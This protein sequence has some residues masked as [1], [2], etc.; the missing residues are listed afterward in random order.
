MNGHR[1]GEQP[2]IKIGFRSRRL[3]RITRRDSHRGAG[4]APTRRWIDLGKPY[5]HRWS[6]L[7]KR[8][9]HKFFLQ[10]I[11][12]ST[13]QAATAATTLTQD[14]RIFPGFMIPCGSIARF[15]VAIKDSSAGLRL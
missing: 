3:F 5:N 13:H 8:D 1:P 12:C 2:D 9:D 11:S 14:A 4:H 7:Q 6:V 10:K 15:T